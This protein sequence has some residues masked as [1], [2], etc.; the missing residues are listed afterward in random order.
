[1]PAA[2]LPVAALAALALITCSILVAI[3]A[4]EMD[5]SASLEKRQMV[6]GAL[7]REAS[8]ASD[9]ARDYG[10]W[11][12]AVDHLY[13][14]VDQDWLSS[15]FGGTL[16]IYVLD[17]GGKTIF[18][19]EPR[20]ATTTA[21]L[22][23]DAPQAIRELIESL[24]IRHAIS[25]DIQ[26]K[27]MIHYYKGQVAIFAASPVLPFSHQRPLPTGPMRY[28]VVVRPLNAELFGAWQDAYA[29]KRVSWAAP[30][31][32]VPEQASHHLFSRTGQDVGYIQWEPV[33]PGSAAVRTLCWLLIGAGALFVLFLVA[34]SRII[35]RNHR[36][37]LLGQRRAEQ[38]SLEREAARLAAEQARQQAEDA[39]EQIA[40]GA[41]R[42][43]REQAEHREAARWHG[44]HN[45]WLRSRVGAVRSLALTQRMLAFARRQDLAPV[46]VS[47]PDLV[48]GMLDLIERTLG[49]AWSVDCDFPQT[50]SQ[51]VADANQLEMAILNL[52]VNARDAMPG[53]GTIMIVAED[54][55]E[56]A[57]LP[58][59]V[60]PGAY[61]KLSVIDTGAGMDEET[62]ARAMEPFFTTKGVGKGTGLGLS[63]VHG[64]TAQL[65]GTFTLESAPGNGTTAS[66]WLP[67]AGGDPAEAQEAVA[68]PCQPSRNLKILAVDD[69]PLILMN[70]AE[71]LQDLGHEVVE[72]T[73]GMRAL[74][75]FV[76][77]SNIDLVITDHAMPGMTGT[78]LAE[79]IDLVRS[80][81]PLILATGYGDL[82]PGFRKT[83]VKL[84]K[85]F[86][87]RQ[88][89]RAVLEAMVKAGI[90]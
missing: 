40:A 25:R 28:V 90:S 84:G 86:N 43:A 49:P 80:D 10:L 29:L 61:L 69:D 72:A 14:E 24:P 32:S 1:M 38:M 21:N 12:D 39:K 81:V 47:V 88:L 83:V 23:D 77:H 41:A 87:Q 65:G 34:S 67:A 5:R 54:V 74:A 6:A 62:L 70:T 45:R 30:G 26:L 20:Q 56:P 2:I 58:N 66:L 33:S 15:N 19:W 22:T 9:T 73:T 89:E 76:E 7:A 50:L 52:A 37:L 53:G 79:Q 11:D 59:A 18:G 13:G 85:P 75:L 64:L 16:P 44:W 63:M 17:D 8:S 31:T 68:A 46:H 27:P 60:V 78:Q 3:L 71:L 4:S 42:E 55:R 36:S 48:K 82:P 57:G 35:L 51:V